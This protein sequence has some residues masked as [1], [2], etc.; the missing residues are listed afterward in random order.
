MAIAAVQGNVPR[1]GLDFN[2]QRRAVLDNHVN[3][4]LQLAQDVKSGRVPAPPT[5][6]PSTPPTG[7]QGQRR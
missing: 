7:P 3:Q 1:L 2:S 5:A 4:T 6:P